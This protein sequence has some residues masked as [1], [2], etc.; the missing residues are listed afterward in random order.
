MSAV[1]IIE[2]EEADYLRT[3]YL[4]TFIDKES[5]HYRQYIGTRTQFE[6]GEAY[7][8]YLWDC[9]KTKRLIAEATAKKHMERSG[10]I[11]IMWDIHSKERIFIP[12][13]WKFPKSALLELPAKSF[14]TMLPSL[15]EDIYVFDFN[16]TWTFA[17]THEELKPG[18]RLCLHIG[19]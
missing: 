12:H 7:T 8:G 1:R 18:K 16:F 6:D 13:Y 3:E 9:F 19:L 11:L 4:T 15:P 10:Q 5:E 14:E 17:L 2:G